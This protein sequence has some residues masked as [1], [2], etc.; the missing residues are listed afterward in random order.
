VGR[1]G[2]AGRVLKEFGAVNALHC[3]TDHDLF[4]GELTNWRVQKITVR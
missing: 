1:F 4:V 3:R 2:R